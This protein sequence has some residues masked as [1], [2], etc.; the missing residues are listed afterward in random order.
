ME[1]LN[2]RILL[3]PSDPARSHAFYG[4][5]L[6]LPVYR[7]FGPPEHRGI[8]Y[9]LGNGLLEVSVQDAQPGFARTLELRVRVRYRRG[10]HNVR[11]VRH[12]RRVVTD[13]RLD[14]RGT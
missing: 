13:H 11:A 5:V 8:V 3:R 14:A 12:V 1:V 2:S 9:L 7:E 6:G 10:A 4:E